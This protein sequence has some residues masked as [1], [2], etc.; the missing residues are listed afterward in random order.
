[1][2]FRPLRPV[3][4]G[5]EWSCTVIGTLRSP[6]GSVPSVDWVG[7]GPSPRDGVGLPGGQLTPVLVSGPPTTTCRLGRR[8]C[9]HRGTPVSVGR[10]R[11]V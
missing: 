11:I 8:V 2:L 10:R 7:V 1:M 5:S 3:D 4:S 6:L 9:R